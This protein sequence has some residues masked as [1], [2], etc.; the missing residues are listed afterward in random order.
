M[1]ELNKSQLYKILEE[2]GFITFAL[3][4]DD[5]FQVP[6]F[7]YTSRTTLEKLEDVLI[8][9]GMTS[10]VETEDGIEWSEWCNEAGKYIIGFNNEVKSEFYFNNNN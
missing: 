4:I 7:H 9:L 6:T 2:R 8:E 1:K 10:K 5:S 3:D